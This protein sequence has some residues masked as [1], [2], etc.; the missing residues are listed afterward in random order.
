MARLDAP[1]LMASSNM[2][3][4]AVRFSQIRSACGGGAPTAA[5]RQTPAGEPPLIGKNSTRQTAP[6]FRIPAVGPTLRD[7]EPPPVAPII[8]KISTRQTSP[9]LRIRAVGPTFGNTERSPVATIISLKY[10]APCS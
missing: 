10:S 7:T 2:Y 8:G 1:G 4:H 3:L 9:L 5:V 6:P